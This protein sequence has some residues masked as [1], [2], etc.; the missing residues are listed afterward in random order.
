MSSEKIIFLKNIILTKSARP[1]SLFPSVMPFSAKL[2]KKF[3][4]IRDKSRAQSN[5]QLALEQSQYLLRGLVCLLVGQCVIGGAQADTVCHALFALAELLSAIY[6][7]QLHRL[8]RLAACQ[9]HH[10]F[11]LADLELIVADEREVAR[12]RREFRQRSDR[13]SV[14]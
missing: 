8:D 4:C 5:A 2:P 7:E 9:L 14:V 13:K 6:V 1:K 11:D 12:D 10:R 3:S